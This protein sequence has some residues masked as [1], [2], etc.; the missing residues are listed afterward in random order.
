MLFQQL[1][2]ALEAEPPDERAGRLVCE[3]LEAP[4][5]LLLR[6]ANL[7]CQAPDFVTNQEP[8]RQPAMRG[9]R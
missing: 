4:R 6:K 9:A 7:G 3:G 5:E 8:Y 2:P 1:A